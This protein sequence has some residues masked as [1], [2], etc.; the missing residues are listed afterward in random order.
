MHQEMSALLAENVTDSTYVDLRC[1]YCVI[2]VIGVACFN[3]SFIFVGMH[4]CA[5]SIA[6]ESW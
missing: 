2:C 4:A 5:G 3:R 1:L 6:A